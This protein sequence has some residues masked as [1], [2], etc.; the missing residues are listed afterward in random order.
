MKAGLET[1]KNVVRN[2]LTF[3]LWILKEFLT[4]P[5]KIINGGGWPKYI[6]IF[7]HI[8]VAMKV[9]SDVYGALEAVIAPIP[10]IPELVPDQSLRYVRDYTSA[11]APAV[12]LSKEGAE[13][14]REEM[15]KQAK[16]CAM[17]SSEQRR[18]CESFTNFDVLTAY[19]KFRDLKKEYCWENANSNNWI[20]TKKTF[21]YDIMNWMKIVITTI[22]QQK[23]CQNMALRIQCN[24]EQF[25]V[26]LMPIQPW[27]NT[28]SP[29]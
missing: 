16:Y 2:V 23:I 18:W 5:V 24:Q 14:V 22:H 7:I 29:G 12:M 19:N 13:E 6:F 26:S 1:V 28:V 11:R 27:V 3:V 20:E 10:T 25:V 9:L 8:F 21:N 17:L 15:T 4:M